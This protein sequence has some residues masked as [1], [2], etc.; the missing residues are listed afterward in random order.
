MRF[1]ICVLLIKLWEIRKFGQVDGLHLD[2]PGGII[3]LLK[4]NKL[5]KAQGQ[6][7]YSDR[8]LCTRPRRNVCRSG[9]ELSGEMRE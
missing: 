8:E 1:F 7:E 3:A 4:Q 9:D 5:Q 6:G 2:L